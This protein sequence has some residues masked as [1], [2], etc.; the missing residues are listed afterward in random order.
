[1]ISLIR[2]IKTLIIYTIIILLIGA[3]AW[4]CARRYIW[5]VK[6]KEI[7]VTRTETRWNIS[8]SNANNQMLLDWSKSPIKIEYKVLSASPEYTK[9]NVFASDANKYTEQEIKVPVAESG[10]FKYYIGGGILVA[11]LVTYVLLK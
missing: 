4:E 9:I 8:P 1:M 11:G 5:T 2:E 3:G 10:N 7:I 6:A